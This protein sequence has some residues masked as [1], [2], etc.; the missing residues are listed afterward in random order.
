MIK[1]KTTSANE[2][3]KCLYN[4]FRNRVNMELKRSKK[5]YYAAYFEEHNNTIK[6]SGEV[7]DQ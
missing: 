2:N 7:L 3:V 6:K 4:I 5:H 1:R